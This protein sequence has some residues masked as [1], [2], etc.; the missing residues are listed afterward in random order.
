M[1]NF[2]MIAVAALI[3]ATSAF[4]QSGQRRQSEPQQKPSSGLTRYDVRQALN[5]QS[6]VFSTRSTANTFLQGVSRRAEAIVAQ[7]EGTLHDDLAAWVSGIGLGWFGWQDASSDAAPA[8][9]V[10]GT[11]G[12]LYIK[13]ITPQFGGTSYWLKAEPTAQAGRYVIHRQVAGEYAQYEETEYIARLVYSDEAEDFVEADDTDIYV[14]YADGVL[15][16]DPVETDEYG[17][18]EWAY[19]LVNDYFGPWAPD[20][21]YGYYW[22]LTIKEFTEHIAVLPTGAE[23]KDM[24]IEHAEGYQDAQVAFV[25]DKVYVQAYA[26]TPGWIVGTRSGD[27]VTFQS[28]QYLGFDEDYNTNLWFWAATV[29]QEY[30]PEYDDYYVNYELTDNIVLEYDAESDVLS[31]VDE[32]TAIIINASQ[33]KVYYAEAYSNPTFFSF[34]EVAAVPADPVIT[35]FWDYDEDYE[36]AEL[37]FEIPTVDVDGNY[38]TPKKL[39]YSVF[40]DNEVFEFE[41][42][43]YPSLTEPLTE[44][45]YGTTPDEYIGETYLCIFFQPAENIGLQSIYRGAG[46][47]KRSNIVLYDVNKG[48]VVGVQSVAAQ[49]SA[50]DGYFDLAGR[51][52]QADAKGFVMKVVTMADGTRK[53]YKVVRK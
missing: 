44:I 5:H 29:E 36:N 19:G 8:A 40:V 15:T 49:P 27:M 12:C 38:I 41:P 13:G 21:S 24:V 9:I 46:V 53:T 17:L 43:E 4:A 6:R 48:E 26:G 39:S 23:V 37:D 50:A 10:E 2:T 30:D 51:R 42:E 32:N 52:V 16:T 11:D 22:N 45:P 7:P 14:N 34:T 1:K 47:E 28:G 33:S 25:G 18:P 20:G 3:A 35:D 31:P